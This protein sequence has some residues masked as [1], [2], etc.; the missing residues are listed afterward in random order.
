[1][2]IS[3]LYTEE[4]RIRTAHSPHVLQPVP[5]HCERSGDNQHFFNAAF[6]KLGKATIVFVM[7]VRPHAT[8]GRIFMKFD[9]RV[10]FEN[11]SRKFKFH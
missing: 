4:Q 3:F 8:T 10:F 2:G 7:S 5:E 6:A 1:M 11:M 9:I